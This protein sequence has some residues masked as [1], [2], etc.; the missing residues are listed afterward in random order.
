MSGG[1]LQL[2][3]NGVSDT[4]LHV[5]DGDSCTY[6]TSSLMFNYFVERLDGIPTKYDMENS[7]DSVILGH[8][9]SHQKSTLQGKTHSIAHEKSLQLRDHGN[10]TQVHEEID[11]V[12]GCRK[13]VNAGNPYSIAHEKTFPLLHDSYESTR[14]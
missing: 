3:A 9:L 7:S 13:P 11:R 12:Y 8:L 6:N 1:I 10:Y 2:V 14:Y 4:W 5:N